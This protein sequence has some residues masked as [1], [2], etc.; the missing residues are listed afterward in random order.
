M[1]DKKR[2][3]GIE[4]LRIVSMYLIAVLHILNKG[5]VLY[6]FGGNTPQYYVLQC[7][8]AATYCSVNCFALISGYVGWNKQFRYSKMLAFWFKVFFYAICITSITRLFVPEMITRGHWIYCFIPITSHQYWYATAYFGLMIFIPILNVGIAQLEKRQFTG[9][10]VLFGLFIVSFTTI[11]HQD[12]YELQRGFSL[13]WLVMLYILG[14]YLSK[15]QTLQKIGKL[16]GCIIFGLLVAASVG[17]DA[18]VRFGPQGI[19]NLYNQEALIA[20]TSPTMVAEAVMLL[21]IFEKVNFSYKVEKWILF[22]SPAVFGVYLLHVHPI[23]FDHMI[24]G[25]GKG[26]LQYPIPVMIACILLLGFAI[27]SVGLCVDLLRIR[28]FK[29]LRVG[30]FCKEICSR[31]EKLV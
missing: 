28:L 2:N 4:L 1:L 10:V 6:S 29:I 23:V 21:A 8:N 5:G 26:I 18:L 7:I 19:G 27:L 16:W 20:Y 11:W 9:V 3:V 25:I 22:F 13:V 30:A 14:G 17:F 31:V 15:Y 24:N 12:S